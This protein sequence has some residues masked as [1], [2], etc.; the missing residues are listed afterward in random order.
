[1]LWSKYLLF[2]G[3]SMIK[4]LFTPF[5]GPAAKLSFLET[6]IFCCSGA[7]LSAA[8]F[9]FL[10]GFF[11]KRAKENQ[12]NALR[13][14]IEK[15]IPLKQKRKFTKVNKLIVKI[16]RSIGIIGISF[17][18]P[19]LLSIPVGSIIVAKFYGNEKKT[20]LLIIVGIAVNGLITTGIAYLIAGFF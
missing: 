14:S 4:F 1:M 10:S 9:Y 15:G 16:K 6:Y 19:L 7:L 5:G 13:I 8:I 3:L 20:F 2:F 12:K 11:L 18:A 17:Y